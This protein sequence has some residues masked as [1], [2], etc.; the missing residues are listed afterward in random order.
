MTQKILHIFLS[1][2]QQP[3]LGA[4]SSLLMSWIICGTK[5]SLSG[6]SSR[7]FSGWFNFSCT[8][9][10]SGVRENLGI[11]LFF[12]SIASNSVIPME[13]TAELGSNYIPVSFDTDIRESNLYILSLP[14]NNDSLFSSSVPFPVT[15]LE[16]REKSLLTVLS[17][18]MR[19]SRSFYSMES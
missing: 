1:E 13:S 10:Y 17:W 3:S 16:M 15:Y 18:V 9:A 19:I 12:L 8:L 2:A 7:Y 6:I 11:G 4:A 5:V 14:L